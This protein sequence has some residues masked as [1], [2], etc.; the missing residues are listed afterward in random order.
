MK[1]LVAD[2]VYPSALTSLR[3]RSEESSVDES[4]RNLGSGAPYKS[5]FELL[6][7]EVDRVVVNRRLLDFDVS[8]SLRNMIELT[9][10]EA[11][12]RVPILGAR[13]LSSGPLVKELAVATKA[14]RPDLI[15]VLN[16][17]LFPYQALD[18]IRQE[19]K[20]I[21]IAAQI[22]SPLPP[23]EFLRGYDV[24]F[25]A[26]ESNLRKLREIGVRAERTNLG[27]ENQSLIQPIEWLKRTKDVSFIGSVGRH[28]KSSTL[29]LL[30]ALD[31]AGVELNIF[32]PQ[33]AN[34]FRRNGLSHRY[35]GLAFG[36]EMLRVLADTKIA[37]N[38]HAK[39]ADATVL[40]LRSFEATG[41][42]AALLTEN[43]LAA[44][45][46]FGQGAALLYE[47]PS[48]AAALAKRF[49]YDEGVL[50]KIAA[51]GREI[52]LDRHSLKAQCRDVIEKISSIRKYHG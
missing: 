31:E 44:K 16:P 20:E 22:S 42:G 4:L 34:F 15:Y 11:I 32:S 45:T 28:H 24:V 10:P 29:P 9:R 38:R 39:F 17:N 33:S 41:M 52:T 46:V 35:R 43:T 37:L 47:S 1:I 13:L 30:K 26:L 12:A 49:L 27:F 14:L 21:F 3:D 8:H 19:N 51:R 6:G 48:D 7:H 23:G 25:S 5:A 36:N 50:S 18:E 40:N 2:S